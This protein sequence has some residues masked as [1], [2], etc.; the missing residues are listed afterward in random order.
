MFATNTCGSLVQ[1]CYNKIGTRNGALLSKFRRLSQEQRIILQV[2]ASSGWALSR[3]RRAAATPSS[4]R[5]RRPIVN[6]KP[7]A[8]HHSDLDHG[9]PKHTSKPQN[10]REYDSDLIVILDMDECLIHSQFFNPS[11]ANVYAHQV[12]RASRKN[13]DFESMQ[14]VETFNFTLPDGDLVQVNK[15]PFLDEFLDKVSSK[16]ETHIFTAAMEVYAGPLLDILDPDGDK[17][18][19][20]WFRESCVF[21]NKTRA[22][23][24]NLNALPLTQRRQQLPIE[25]NLS[26]KDLPR[27]VLVDNNP[28]SFLSNPSNGILVS[29]FFNDP[30]DK[31]LPA[32]VDLLDELDDLD[33]V[34]PVLDMKFGL[35]DALA[36]ITGGRHSLSDSE[37]ESLNEE[38][39]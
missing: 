22:Y 27:V 17:I 2:R 30:T 28:L 38:A 31:T 29:S 23:V 20:R 13:Q 4:L 33:D 14:Q 12:A 35:K 5:Q 15:R 26:P 18:A 19:K 39:V 32:V 34:R 37:E 36:E 11:G 10:K 25:F 7:I 8:F 3:S 24:K 16:Y 1:Q 21:D 9:A 6:G